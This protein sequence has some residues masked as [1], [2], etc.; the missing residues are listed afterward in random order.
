MKPNESEH[1]HD[2][3]DGAP[4][5]AGQID[6]AQLH[7]YQAAMNQLPSIRI[8]PP[9]DFT[10]R[11]MG[12]LP[13]HPDRTWKNWLELLWP[14]QGEWIMPAMAGSLATALLMLLG[15]WLLHPA[16]PSESTVRVTYDVNLTNAQSVELVG[17]FN[18][19]TP[20]TI[21]LKGP[22]ANGRWTAEVLLP[23]GRHE[24]L[25]LVD[26]REWMTDPTAVMRRP[27]GFGRENA[28]I[29]I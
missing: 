3:L 21:V 10:A 7:K 1:L 29:D 25:F 24:Y 20:G 2:A 23:P 17:T 4:V 16:I 14:R 11:V 9:S 15:A 27:D 26:G 5:K 28:V 6:A 22:N 18:N 8:Q 12:A 19:W 13:A